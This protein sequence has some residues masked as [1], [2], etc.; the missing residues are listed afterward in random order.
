MSDGTRR[1]SVTLSPAQVDEVVRAAIPRGD[2]GGALGFAALIS[3]ALDRLRIGV[4]VDTRVDE[5]ADAFPEGGQ[6]PGGPP[7]DELPITDGHG[8]AARYFPVFDDR[9]LSRSLLRGLAILTC[10]GADGEPLGIMDIATQLE[11]SPST[12]YRYVLTLVEIGLLERCPRTRKYRL[13]V[14]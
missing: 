9:R 8:S 2:P 13:S 14:L 11:L 12:A 10:F 7:V 3:A 1:I 5:G 4:P 6:Q